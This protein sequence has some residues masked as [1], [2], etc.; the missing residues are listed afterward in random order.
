[1]KRLFDVGLKNLFQLAMYRFGQRVCARR[2]SVLK[3]V[4]RR[5]QSPRPV[6]ENLRLIHSVG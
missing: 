5:R 2:N 3:R 6:G 4:A 1:M